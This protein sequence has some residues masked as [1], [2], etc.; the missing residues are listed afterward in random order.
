[1]DRRRRRAGCIRFGT[2]AEQESCTQDGESDAQAEILIM[3]EH[4]S[5][6]DTSCGLWST[7]SKTASAA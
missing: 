6:T 4:G 1:R 5:S 2:A 7:A 3:Y